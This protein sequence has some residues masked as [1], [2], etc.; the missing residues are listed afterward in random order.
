MQKK[1]LI[2]ALILLGLLVVGGSFWYL[3]DDRVDVTIE[4]VDENNKP[5]KVSIYVVEEEDMY[6][7]R[8]S[9]TDANGQLH[10][11]KLEAGL[12]RFDI[13][14]DSDWEKIDEK[15]KISKEH[16]KFRFVLKKKDL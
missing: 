6:P 1:R 14:T 12:Y 2:P 10:L 13:L 7:F 16:S 11:K 9:S 3:Y 8:P 5:Q 4:V 15:K